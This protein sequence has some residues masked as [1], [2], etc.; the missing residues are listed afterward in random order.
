MTK[1]LLE[2]AGKHDI[3]LKALLYT[4]FVLAKNKRTVGRD[5][6]FADSGKNECFCR[7]QMTF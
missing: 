7:R 5:A 6:S 2:V 3:S 1:D 4:T